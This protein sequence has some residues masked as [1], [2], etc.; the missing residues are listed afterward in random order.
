[1]I[2]RCS[3]LLVC[4]HRMHRSPLWGEYSQ[5]QCLEALPTPACITFTLTHWAPES[6]VLETAMGEE[7]LQA[8]WGLSRAVPC[9]PPSLCRGHGAGSQVHYFVHTPCLSLLSWQ[10][11]D[12]FFSVL[13]NMPVLLCVLWECFWGLIVPCFWL[14][15]EPQHHLLP[16][17][18]FWS[19]T[20]YA[21][22]LSA[23][24]RGHFLPFPQE[25]MEPL[26]HISARSDTLNFTLTQ[27]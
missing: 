6:P 12:I 5:A 26:Q 25:V 17:A 2:Q 22:N 21:P 13:P 4:T 23:Q 16:A 9:S 24:T 15:G 10:G 1:M 3:G 8:A 14:P 19:P 20:F 7:E 11:G 18:P 27:A